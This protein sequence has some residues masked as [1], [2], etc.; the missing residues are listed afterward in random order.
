MFN[1]FRIFDHFSGTILR[2]N[3]L[4]VVVQL[5]NES[6]YLCPLCLK[7]SKW[8]ADGSDLF[9]RVYSRL[10]SH[11]G[12]ASFTT[13]SPVDVNGYSCNTSAQCC[14]CI[15]NYPPESSG[16]EKCTFCDRKCN[17]KTKLLLP[18]IRKKSMI[19]VCFCTKHVL[20]TFMF[21]QAYEF[22]VFLSITSEYFKKKEMN[23]RKRG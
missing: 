14:S 4:G 9:P 12:I 18:C 13:I 3:M 17:P 8:F 6:F 16:L 22:D 5:R 20:P 1:F 23:K 7:I 10:D 21:E 2:V 19:S 11:D 15:P